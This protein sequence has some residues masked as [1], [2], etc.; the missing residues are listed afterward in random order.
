MVWHQLGVKTHY[1]SLGIQCVH[2]MLHTQASVTQLAEC[3]PRAEIHRRKMTMN[4]Y[5]KK[6]MYCLLVKKLGLFYS[7]LTAHF[8]SRWLLVCLSKN[9]AY[10]L[11]KGTSPMWRSDLRIKIS[12]KFPPYIF[13]AVLDG[14]K[15]LP[16]CDHV[17]L[18]Q[19]CSVVWHASRL[20]HQGPISLRLQ[21]S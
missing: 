11:I 2:I 18:S 13:M 19:S 10:I 21:M 12:D 6:N 8:L 15:M 4:L 5:S 3:L 20:C 16:E 1:K 7:S 9:R 14:I 17:H